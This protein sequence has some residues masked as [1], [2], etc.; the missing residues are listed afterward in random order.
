MINT[1]HHGTKGEEIEIDAAIAVNLYVVLL[2]G[3]CDFIQ[4]KFSPLCVFY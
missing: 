1:D 4:V 2:S 3:A